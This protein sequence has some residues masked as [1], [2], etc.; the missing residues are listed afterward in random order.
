M[1]CKPGEE[2]IRGFVRK[3]MWI[4]TGIIALIRGVCYLRNAVN[5]ILEI[6]RDQIIRSYP[7]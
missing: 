1:I 4:F 6:E 7:Y 3:G 5:A 2:I